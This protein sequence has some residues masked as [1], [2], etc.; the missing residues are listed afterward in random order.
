MIDKQNWGELDYLRLTYRIRALREQNLA[1][2]AKTEWGKVLK[3]AEGKLDRLVSLQSIAANWNWPSEEEDILWLVVNKFPRQIDAQQRL[4]GLLL[5]R[6]KTRSL[7]TL[8]AT[9]CQYDTN[10]IP[11]KNNLA[12][13]AMLLGAN[14]HKPNDLAREIYEKKPDD[15][16]VA[17]TYAY[18]LYLQKKTAEALQVMRKLEPKKLEDPSIAGYYGLIL[19]ASGEKAEAKKYFSL[20][21]VKGSPLPEETELFRRSESGL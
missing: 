15:P 14:E 16:Y 10:N 12:S 3:G 4:G 7:L 17:S 1:S 21:K 11:A 6:G 5:S 13:I 18:S 19:A 8:Y 20:F 2:T 9:L